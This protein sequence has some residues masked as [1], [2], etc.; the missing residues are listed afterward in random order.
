MLALSSCTEVVVAV[1]RAISQ[2]SREARF[3][4]QM[5]ANTYH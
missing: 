1:E 4:Q 2:W 5:E 3:R